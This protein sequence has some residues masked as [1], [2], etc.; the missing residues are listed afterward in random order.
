MLRHYECATCARS[1]SQ[2]IRYCALHDHRSQSAGKPYSDMCEGCFK[3][4]QE[5]AQASTKAEGGRDHVMQVRRTLDTRTTD[6]HYLRAQ[7][8]L[9]PG[10]T[11][12]AGVVSTLSTGSYYDLFILS[13]T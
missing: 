6:E 7:E 9:H 8:M 12:F 2:N 4:T 5:N 10:S 13:L 3:E 1:V 11:E